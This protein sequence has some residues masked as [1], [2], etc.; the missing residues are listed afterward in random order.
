MRGVC[1]EVGELVELRD[2]VAAVAAAGVQSRRQHLRGKDGGI[3]KRGYGDLN[4]VRR[5]AGR[6]ATSS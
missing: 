2:D 3:L 1:I 4:S 6:E 5:S